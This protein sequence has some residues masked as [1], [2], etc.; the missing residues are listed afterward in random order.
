MNLCYNTIL[1]SSFTKFH[2]MR[3]ADEDIICSFVFVA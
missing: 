3:V 2:R 1:E